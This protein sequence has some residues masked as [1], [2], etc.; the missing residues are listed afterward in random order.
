MSDLGTGLLIALTGL[1]IAGLASIVGIWMERDTSRPIKWA[2]ILSAL[3]LLATGVSMFQSIDDAASSA[4]L[5]EDMARM[6]QQLDKISTADGGNPALNEFISGELKAQSRANPDIVNKLQ[7]RIEADGGDP[8]AMFGKHMDASDLPN[9]V[10]VDT[11]AVQAKRSEDTSKLKEKLAV[12]VKRAE[13]AETKVETT[14][15]EAKAT[16]A[17]KDKQITKAND[18]ITTLNLKV[19]ELEKQLK[20]AKRT[21][22][23]STVWTKG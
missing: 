3:I 21:G 13:K 9:G 2:A 20:A 15:K 6:L 8:S 1:F 16:H 11:K 7:E 12:A 19:A 17:V 4:K 23:G 22:G 10:Q 18:E 14:E 5:E